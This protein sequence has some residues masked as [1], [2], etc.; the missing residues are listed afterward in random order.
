VEYLIKRLKH[1]DPNNW[2]LDKWMESQLYLIGNNFKY[3][4]I[5]YLVS[6]LPITAKIRLPSQFK[7]VWK[8]TEKL[9]YKEV[10]VRKRSI[11]E[12][13]PKINQKL[14]DSEYLSEEEAAMLLDGI[15]QQLKDAGLL[16][17]LLEQ[18]ELERFQNLW[19]NNVSEAVISESGT[20]ESDGEFVLDSDSEVEEEPGSFL[21]SQPADA[22]DNLVLTATFSAI[23]VALVTLSPPE[24]RV[25]RLRFDDEWSLSKIAQHSKTLGFESLSTSKVSHLIDN[26]LKKMIIVM[27]REVAD[28]GEVQLQVPGL[29]DILDE[30][31]TKEWD[32]ES[33]LCQ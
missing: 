7:D 18:V 30:W 24:R 15:V 20:S 5:G 11:P 32:D 6:Q 14:K 19:R 2:T 9:L 1:F 8:T 33:W 4:F 26:A 10:I 29:K 3:M 23:S 16:A 22:P 25:L 12:I 17:K 28:I 13:L 31:G 21:V 27:R